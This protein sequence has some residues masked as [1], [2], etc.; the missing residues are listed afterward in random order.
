MITTN[1]W[2][3]NVF[4]SKYSGG[5]IIRQGAQDE[6][7]INDRAINVL[8]TTQKYLLILINFINPSTLIILSTYLIEHILAS[9]ILF[10]HFVS[11]GNKIKL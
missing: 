3:K 5:Q 6:Q 11:T 1:L 2:L 8:L 4:C 9:L 7:M 10:Y